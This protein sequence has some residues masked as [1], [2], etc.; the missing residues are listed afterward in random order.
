MFADITS[1]YTIF[2]VQGWM[3]E[4]LTL[5]HLYGNCHQRLVQVSV[6]VLN[7]IS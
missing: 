2:V 3:M 5:Q 1:S 6:A 7:I 4:L